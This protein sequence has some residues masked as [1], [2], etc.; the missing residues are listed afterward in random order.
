M[1][2]EIKQNIF[3]KFISLNEVWGKDWTQKF[4]PEDLLPGTALLNP[5]TNMDHCLH[6][7]DFRS[8]NYRKPLVISH[9]DY[10]NVTR[11]IGGAESSVTTY[12][13]GVFPAHNEGTKFGSRNVLVVTPII[14]D[15]DKFKGYE[16]LLPYFLLEKELELQEV[17]P[18][19]HNRN[20]DEATLEQIRQDAKKSILETALYNGI[21]IDY[22]TFHDILYP[23]NSQDQNI[24]LEAQR[25][26]LA[27]AD[28][29]GE[30]S[31][32]L[33]IVSGALRTLFG[34]GQSTEPYQV[35]RDRQK[36]IKF[37]PLQLKQVVYQR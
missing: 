29:I 25:R 30:Y 16:N 27:E 8:L 23:L 12:V 36:K 32:P 13:A 2:I 6:E 33:S 1:P 20:L 10:I 24:R 7:H 28:I 9:E 5:L 3:K 37:Q 17:L 18:L 11:E 34:R 21:L 4:N 35:L 31:S 26:K 19:K 14:I 15:G 22:L